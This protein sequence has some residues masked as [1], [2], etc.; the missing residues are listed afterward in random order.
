MKAKE[1][2]IDRLNRVLTIDLT[3]VNQYFIHAEMCKNWGFERIAHSFRSSS[4][5][6]MRDAQELIRHILYLDGVPNLQRLNQV[7][8]GESV[9]E[10]LKLNLQSENEAVEVL[11]EAI[12]HC[13]RVEDYTTRSLLEA[14]VRSEEE[15]IDWLETQLE[16][17]NLIG[18]NLYLN[19]QIHNEDD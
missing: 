12:T 15:H 16:T 8:V 13:S 1:G 7:K 17:I 9:L 19:Q 2:I 5:E 10:D 11:T 14:M 3:A 6:E 4:L 18:L